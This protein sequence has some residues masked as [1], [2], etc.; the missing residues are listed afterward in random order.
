MYD[1]RTI[2]RSFVQDIIAKEHE[3][4]KHIYNIVATELQTLR[5]ACRSYIKVLDEQSSR[6]SQIVQQLSKATALSFDKIRPPG[7]W[8][9]WTADNSTRESF[10]QLFRSWLIKCKQAIEFHFTANSRLTISVRFEKFEQSLSTM[11][12]G[13]YTPVTAYSSNDGNRP[14]K[15]S[16]TDV[17]SLAFMDAR[18][19]FGE[20]VQQFHSLLY[21][22]AIIRLVAEY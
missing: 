1:N 6:I 4:E 22:S 17:R 13:L 5:A 14:E 10:A 12:E 16:R 18:S 7:L 19:T 3:I 8:T 11:I 2:E 15:R 20:I 21:W 9:E